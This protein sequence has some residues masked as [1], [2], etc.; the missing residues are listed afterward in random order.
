MEQHK[1]TY[2]LVY[3][4]ILQGVNFHSEDLLRDSTPLQY[5]A[6]YSLVSFVWGDDL[7]NAETIQH[8]KKLNVDGVIYDR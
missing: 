5:A 1:V 6:K 8:F 3:I 4:C 2:L 7:N